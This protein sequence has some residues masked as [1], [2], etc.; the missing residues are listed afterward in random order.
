MVNLL[1]LQKYP[2]VYV[3]NA[4]NII[5]CKGTVQKQVSVSVEFEQGCRKT[6]SEIVN[7]F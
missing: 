3:R 2:K 7:N 4:L 5:T 1:T 6:K